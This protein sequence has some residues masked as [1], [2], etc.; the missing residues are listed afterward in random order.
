[1]LLL[2]V[3]AG[4]CSTTVHMLD[5]AP[6]GENIITRDEW[7]ST[8]SKDGVTI[9]VGPLGYWYVADMRFGILI[10]NDSQTAIE[11]GA[12]DLKVLV[13]GHPLTLI[14][15]AQMEKD[16]RR[17]RFANRLSAGVAAA[18]GQMPGFAASSA[19]VHTDFVRGLG[20]AGERESERLARLESIAW[21]DTRLLR[22]AVWGNLTLAAKH[23]WRSEKV[24]P[25]ERMLRTVWTERKA[26]GSLG[27]QGGHVIVEMKLGDRKFEYRFDAVPRSIQEMSAVVR[28][29]DALAA[30]KK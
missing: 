2:S 18:S 24:A 9:T 19:M 11:I 28:K 14:A 6:G 22:D 7:A 1:M 16:A 23:Y 20:R 12:D 21:H 5:A 8:L 26:V 30:E 10:A 27:G 17:E 4:G 15:H 3:I 13:N 29:R 25:G